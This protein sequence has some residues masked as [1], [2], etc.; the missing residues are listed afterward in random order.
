MKIAVDVGGTFT[1]IV[2]VSDGEVFVAKTPTTPENISEGFLKAV[3]MAT[4]SFQD[5]DE[6]VHGTTVVLNSLLVGQRPQTALITTKGFRDVRK[7]RYIQLGSYLSY[8]KLVQR[9]INGNRP[10]R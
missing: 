4:K 9:L 6:I 3:K 1:D 2:A 8:L 5:V 10:I 7:C